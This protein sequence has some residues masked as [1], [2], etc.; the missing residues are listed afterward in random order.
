VVN[1]NNEPGRSYSDGDNRNGTLIARNSDGSIDWENTDWLG[2]MDTEI[3]FYTGFS[4]VDFDGNGIPELVIHIDGWEWWGYDIYSFV[5]GNVVYNSMFSTL[6][7][8][9]KTNYYI[10]IYSY[11]GE[12]DFY[13]YTYQFE[14]GKFVPV[15]GYAE[16]IGKGHLDND[17][18]RILIG[19]TIYPLKDF[20][21]KEGFTWFEYS[22]S[23][24]FETAL[25]AWLATQ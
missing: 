17:D 2:G 20:F 4:L 19:D 8:E 21:G 23:P 10:T 16:I 12:V 25:S 7:M 13:A 3:E 11:T 22:Y 6:F 14:N 5:D 1:G 15:E 24:D 18:F 9:I